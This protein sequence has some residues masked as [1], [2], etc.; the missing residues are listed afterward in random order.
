[1]ALKLQS[2]EAHEKKKING[3]VSVLA[4]SALAVLTV[5]IVYS[6]I[7]DNIQINEYREQYETLV[8][9]TDTVIE[10]NEKITRYLE[11]DSTLNEYIENIAR[12]R[13]D[14]AMPDERIFYIVPSAG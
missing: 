5:F 12:E 3:F 6:I 7:R 11:D 8:A 1:M 4:Y 2:E 13:L 9:Q 10:D 14:F